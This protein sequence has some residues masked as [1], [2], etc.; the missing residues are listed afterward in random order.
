MTGHGFTY[1]AQ[2][3]LNQM[4]PTPGN[5]VFLRSDGDN[6]TAYCMPAPGMVTPGSKSNPWGLTKRE[7]DVCDALI[8]GGSADKHIARQLGLEERTVQG[9]MTRIRERMSVTSRVD[10]A[11]VYAHWKWAGVAT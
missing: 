1:H 9:Y 3:L 10:I 2:A 8:A 6:V 4:R 5:G 11:L 7:L